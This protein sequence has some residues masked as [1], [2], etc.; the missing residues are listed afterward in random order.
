MKLRQSIL[1]LVAILTSF[2]LSSYAQEYVAE[3]GGI[4]Y[5]SLQGAIDA[6]TEGATITLLC[7]L[8][9]ASDLNNAVKVY[10]T[11]KKINVSTSTLMAKPSM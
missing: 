9:V 2:S 5:N 6:A 4:N 11:L 8:E 10:T 1:A 7:D 3:T